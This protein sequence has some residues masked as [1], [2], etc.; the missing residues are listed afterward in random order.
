M[1][2][3]QTVQKF[4]YGF[5]KEL[6]NR[7]ERHDQSKMAPPEVAAFTEYTPK[8]QTSTYGSPEYEGF[9]KAMAP[10]LAH[11]YAHNRHHPEHFKE[12]VD[13]MNL[14]DLLEMFADWAAASKRH[15]DGNIRKS[16]EL[17]RDRFKLS[18]QIIRIFENTVE[19]LGED[20]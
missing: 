20:S 3:I 12:G 4:L 13:E 15:H 10:A 16:I 19:L 1:R 18:P 8:L 11:H 14:I 2:H 6:L 9:K 7:C 5:I 17:N